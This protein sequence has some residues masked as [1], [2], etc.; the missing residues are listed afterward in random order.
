M[1]P[2]QPKLR[3]VALVVF[4]AALVLMLM[5]LALMARPALA[6]LDLK[7]PW[8]MPYDVGQKY[9]GDVPVDITS[10][11]R[12]YT[13]M[14]ENFVALNWPQLAGGA[15]GQPDIARGVATCHDRILGVQ[16]ADQMIHHIFG[17]S[18]DA[19]EEA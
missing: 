17:V 12:I 3:C 14:W 15:P 1:V 11:V 19:I 6:Q 8:D 9:V 13:F 4:F 5:G 7:E 2:N 18:A 16:I 10:Q